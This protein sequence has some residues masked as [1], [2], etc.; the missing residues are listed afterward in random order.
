MKCKSNCS[1]V[2]GWQTPIHSACQGQPTEA[3][4]QF[5][6]LRTSKHI[7]RKKSL[8][9][10]QQ[11]GWTDT[12]GKRPT[13]VDITTYWKQE[14]LFLDNL[15][16][17]SAERGCVVVVVIVGGAH[18][19]AGPLP[20]PDPGTL[21]P[22]WPQIPPTRPQPVT[23]WRLRWLSVLVNPRRGGASK[24]SLFNERSLSGLPCYR[25]L[26]AV[27][28]RRV[29]FQC[30]VVFKCPVGVWRSDLASTQPGDKPLISENSAWWHWFLMCFYC[31]FD[32]LDPGTFLCFTDRDRGSHSW[33]N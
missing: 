18:P 21:P 8:F 22:P 26:N 31:D 7:F 30:S 20:A 29:H 5:F 32:Q 1:C 24:D 4:K 28:C 14:F 15:E 13:G 33:W 27:K 2:C 23:L 3:R 12:Q 19:D 9:S 25:S 16:K 10:R 11:G 6:K 17:F